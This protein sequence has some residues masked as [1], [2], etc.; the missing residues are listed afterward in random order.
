MDMGFY[1][2]PST[3]HDQHTPDVMRTGLIMAWKGVSDDSKLYWSRDLGNDWEPQRVIPGVGA[4]SP[5]K[6]HPWDR[7]L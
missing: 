3:S 5:P 2:Q 1:P 4:W 6:T 7:H